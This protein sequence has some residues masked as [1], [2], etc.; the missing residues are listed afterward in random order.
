MDKLSELLEKLFL[1]I[2]LSEAFAV[3]LKD[4]SLVLLVLIISII[5]F[6]I[7]KKVFLKALRVVTKRTKSRWD[8]ELFEQ[9]VFHKLAYLVPAYIMQLLLPVVLVNYPDTSS[10][11]EAGIHLYMLII[12]MITI[13]A[14]FNSVYKIY[15]HYEISNDIPIKGYVQVAKIILYTIFSILI[16]SILINK[17]PVTLLAGLGA[18]SAV[19]MLIFKDVILGFVGGIQLTL[20]NMVRP[21][22]W[23]SMPNYGADGTVIDIT[24]TTVKVQNWNKTISTIPTYSLISETF[25]NWR[26]MEESGGRRIKRSI[27]INTESVKFCTPDMIERFKK[28][29]IIN[30]YVIDKEVELKE[31]NSKNN[32]DE[33]VVVNGRRQTNIGIFRE[34]LKAYL[35]NHPLINVDMTFLVRQL[36]PGEMGI[37][38]EIYVFSKVQEWA[39][40]EDIQSDIFDH[41]FASVGR[42]DLQIFQNP[43]GT[44]FKK[45][46]R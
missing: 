3:V 33:T 8:D 6:Y 46:S 9:R 11:I 25:Q 20:N 23:I 18:M 26:G 10:F 41:I 40:Y 43:T 30:K 4:I 32:I 7:A 45:L 42:F 29:Q 38:L 35:K 5:A 19:L 36:E 15:Q 2:G 12:L 31:Y 27:N 34:Y 16:I 17:N 22:D 44:D 13:N 28:I 1:N 39:E 37:P 21:G 24:L 14:F